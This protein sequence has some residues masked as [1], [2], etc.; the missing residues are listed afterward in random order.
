M[1]ARFARLF[2]IAAAAALPV[3]Y[4]FQASAAGAE[5]RQEEKESE[6]GKLMGQ[7]NKHM[8]ALKKNVAAADQK[9]ANVAAFT[10]LA[11]LAVKCKAHVPELAKTDEE[12]KQYA[13]MLDRM[14]AAGKD[15]AKA[16]QGG[17]LAGAQAAYDALKKAQKEGHQKF[18]PKDN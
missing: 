16:A 4:A 9:D 5:V 10:A 18:K 17:D 13:D 3:P 6:L 2:L 11:E 1:H 15:G 12:K 8:K 14:A 7:M